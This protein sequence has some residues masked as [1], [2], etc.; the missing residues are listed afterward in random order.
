MK[1]DKMQN[2][3]PKADDSSNHPRPLKTKLQKEKYLL[4]FINTGFIDTGSDT[5]I[6][7]LH[8][9]CVS[10]GIMSDKTFWN[11]LAEICNKHQVFNVDQTYFTTHTMYWY[12][13]YT[14]SLNSHVKDL[15]SEMAKCET[16]SDLKIL[17]DN[18]E[19]KET[20]H[21]IHMLEEWTHKNT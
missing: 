19:S 17:L 7:S 1:K 4:Q 16:I 3:N 18:D 2:Q 8:K 20:I 5:T 6:D 9:Q 15:F 11:A 13:K 10:S 14:T 21:S 12:I